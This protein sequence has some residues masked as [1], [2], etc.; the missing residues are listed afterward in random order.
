MY[1]LLDTYIKSFTFRNKL[2][3]HFL[4]YK[5]MC[6]CHYKATNSVL[7]IRFNYFWS[8]KSVY[9]LWND[10]IFVIQTYVLICYEKKS[11]TLNC[12]AWE[13]LTTCTECWRPLLG[14]LGTQ[15]NLKPLKNSNK[16]IIIYVCVTEQKKA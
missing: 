10:Q 13:I 11:L 9:P 4:S 3:N 2:P 8:Y 7:L 5:P 6:L 16:K 15:Y 14:F 1:W 12:I